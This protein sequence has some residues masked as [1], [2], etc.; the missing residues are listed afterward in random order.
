MLL[1]S[2]LSALGFSCVRSSLNCFKFETL[3]IVLIYN[4]GPGGQSGST[5][6]MNKMN[7]LLNQSFY[8]SGSEPLLVGVVDLEVLRLAVVPEE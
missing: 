2:W 7:P 6:G 5:S 1:S 4:S 3:Y 8:T